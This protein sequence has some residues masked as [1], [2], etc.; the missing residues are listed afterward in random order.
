[1]T[2]G[3][4]PVRPVNSSEQGETLRMGAMKA[5]Q[6]VEGVPE[7]LYNTTCKQAI[8]KSSSQS[9]SWKD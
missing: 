5:F 9:L 1:M 3:K 6:S 8:D 4:I 2:K 7:Q